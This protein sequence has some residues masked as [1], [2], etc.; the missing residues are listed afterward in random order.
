MKGVNT[1]LRATLAAV[2]VITVL[3]VMCI[4][5]VPMGSGTGP[6]REEPSATRDH[7]LDGIGY[8]LDKASS[9]LIGQTFPGPGGKLGNF[10]WT[11]DLD[12]DGLTDL[13]V[14]SSEAPGN[15]EVGEENTGY[16]YIWLGSGNGI[17]GVTD[18]DSEIPDILIRGGHEFSRLLSSMDVGDLN[19]DGI[20]DIVLGVS[21]HP[22]C[23]RVFVLWGK[24]GGWP[25]II[26]LHDPGRL[27]PNGDPYGFLRTDDYMIIGG[28]LS[29]VPWPEATY[30]T[31]DTVIVEDLDRN[32]LEDLI[33]S[34]PG[35]HHVVIMWGTGSKFT[36]GSD[37]TIVDNQDLNA[38]FGDSM[39]MGDIDND[40]WDDLVVGAPYQRNYTANRYE[41]GI[42]FVYLNASRFRSGTDFDSFELAHPTIWGSG[43]Y[44]RF[45][46]NIQLNDI[47]DD[48]YDDILVGSPDADGPQN[49]RNGAGE[50]MIFEG[51]IRASF[52]RFMDAGSSSDKTIFGDRI[53][54]GDDPGDAV[55]RSFSV[56][57]IDADG[58]DE[59]VIGF[60]RR[61]NA[62][63]TIVGCIAG[64]ET[65]QVFTTPSTSIDLRN[66]KA[67]FEFWGRTQNDNLGYFV[68]IG[69]T[70][71]DGADELFASAPGAD[72]PDDSRVDAGEVYIFN[73]SLISIGEIVFSGPGFQ[74]DL[75]NPGSTR[76][77]MNFT[78]RHSID[79]RSVDNAFAVFEPG[80]IDDT[81]GYIDG[82]FGSDQNLFVLDSANSSISYMGN[83]GRISLVLT[84]PLAMR[85]DRA[86]DVAIFVGDTS[87]SQVVRYFIDRFRVVNDIILSESAEILVDGEPIGKMDAWLEPSASI[88]FSHLYMYY[89]RPGRP[90]SVRGIVYLDLYRDGFVVDQVLLTSSG[91]TLTDTIPSADRVVYS[92]KPRSAFPPPG[93]GPPYLPNYRG[94]ARFEFSID[95]DAPSSVE[96]LFLEPDPGRRSLFDDDR[97]WTVGWESPPGSV[98]DG[99][100]TVRGFEVTVEGQEPETSRRSGGL[101]GT[102][103]NGSEFR[104]LR[105]E[106]VDGPLDFS[107]KQWGTFGPDPDNLWYFSFSIR[108]DGWF[109]VP[110][111]RMYQF[112]VSG[113]EYGNAMVVLDDTS[114][115]PWT[116][117][118]TSQNSLQRFLNEGDMLPIQ[119]YYYYQTSDL[120]NAE[121][122]FSL[123]YLDEKGM[124]VPIPSS[125]LFHPSNR[126][127]IRLGFEDEFSVSVSAFDWVGYTSEP[128]SI[129]GYLDSRD[130][131]FNLSG[132]EPWY[133]SPTPTIVIGIRDPTTGGI[134]CSGIDIDSIEYRIKERN[135]EF[136]SD[137]TGEGIEYQET[138]AGLE[139]PVQLIANFTLDLN[140]SWRGSIQWRVSDIVGNGVESSS[141]DFG[142]DSKGPEFELLS[143]NIQIVQDEGPNTLIVKVF[144]RPGAGIDQDTIMYRLDTGEGWGEWTS[145]VVNGSGVEIIFDLTVDLP[146]G[147][148][149]VQLSAR[150]LVGNE[151]RSMVYS[152]TTQPVVINR[153]PI[154]GIK[155]P[156]NASKIRLGSPLTLDATDTVDDGEGPL[157]S[158]R[159]TWISN[160]DGFLGSGLILDVYLTNLGEHRI[161]L[162]VDDGEFNVST[163]IY[164]TVEENT[165]I[166]EPDDDD[167]LDRPQP[168]YFTPLMIS[169]ILIILL[170]VGFFLFYRRYRH[171]RDEETRLDFVER[172][173][174]DIEYEIRSEEEERAM[175]IPTRRSE[176]SGEEVE[177]ERKRLYG[178]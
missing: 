88:S 116:D 155:L 61:M 39:V 152:I 114:I 38:K 74:D 21:L 22:E 105:I 18:L 32:G 9:M 165:P 7:S 170:A 66:V 177:E 127:D 5:P 96:G 168:D 75:L 44:D 51:G 64:Y 163:S 94:E 171:R 102:Y 132:F 169:F 55:G 71:N 58:A 43:S 13:A 50:L 16:V 77:Y 107:K 23:G 178:D 26:D 145:L 139:A 90:E 122:S 106:K 129:T 100:S 29:P 33:F 46:F 128:A 83:V 119:V 6:S 27:S 109:R 91:S 156:L 101:F 174:D 60:P 56:G 154:P 111:S 84:P 160:I 8:A 15:P 143:P 63:G 131:V 69:D 49:S 68:H 175:G 162:Y 142:I 30:D 19:D 98:L 135:S 104:Q 148:N 48:G 82:A 24:Q 103:Y 136:Y 62:D 41:C 133:R 146:S 14:A 124:M 176:R 95:D 11:G 138:Q 117:L 4:L 159:Y 53:S 141:I 78:F 31:G 172:T 158:L 72:G 115:I 125:E 121:S 123:R 20:D 161:R 52:P 93:E 97:D 2:S 112:S 86:Y 81:V 54:S 167:D 134:P 149:K 57:D 34:S 110:S 80:Y 70:T 65:N 3:L 25:S 12:M 40:G 89:D 37:M 28:H 144:D 76:F 150:D 10:I 45:G 36:L 157:P 42:V 17:R 137:W 1:S 164:I 67:R 87:G 99:S 85:I 120:Q 126:T 59:L 108:W 140:P 147:Q 73:G 118:K 130:P 113:T 79:P 92:I 151:E 47:D 166:I 35:W 153:P 173:D